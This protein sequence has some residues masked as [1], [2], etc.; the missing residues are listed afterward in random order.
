MQYCR[1][2]PG[3]CSAPTCGGPP[4]LRGRICG[5]CSGPCGRLR[6]LHAHHVNQA[7]DAAAIACAYANAARSTN[8]RWTWSFT[9]HGPTEFYDVTRF[10]LAD[11]VRDADAVVCISDFCRAQVMRNS[12]EDDW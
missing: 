11:K 1:R 9:V 12:R 5:R 2:G 10:R 4:G 6:H 3:T 8:S 7:A